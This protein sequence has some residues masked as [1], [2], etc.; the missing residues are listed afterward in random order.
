MQRAE[1]QTEIILREQWIN[2]A[3]NHGAIAMRYGASGEEITQAVDNGAAQVP[4]PRDPDSGK[5]V[6]LPR[7]GRATAEALQRGTTVEH[8]K[9]RM[10]VCLWRW[11]IFRRSRCRS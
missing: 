8:I 1:W 4:H 5:S 11:E 10:A 9:S 7:V 2:L 3:Y 6:E